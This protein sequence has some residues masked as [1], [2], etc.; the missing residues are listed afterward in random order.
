MSDVAAICFVTRSQPIVAMIA[1]NNASR[2]PI[3]LVIY[4]SN[5]PG[6]NPESA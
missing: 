1:T 2:A 5:Q 6:I 3:L 4:R